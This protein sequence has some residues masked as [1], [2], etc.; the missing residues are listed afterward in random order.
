MK[1][2]ATLF[3]AVLLAVVVV[4]H[5][6]ETRQ[7]R[8]GV[9]AYR[10]DAMTQR[11]WTPTI[12]YL[13]K[14]IPGYSFTLV[15]L[16]NNDIE[17]KVANHM[18]DFVLTNPG[19]YI[20]LQSRYG[21]NRI[22]T[23]VRR[24]DAGP[25]TEFGAVIFTR[26]D[27][28]DIRTLQ[29]LRDKRFAAVHPDGFGGWWMAKQ[30]LIEHGINPERAFRSLSFRGLPQRKIVS[31][32]LRGTVDAGTVRTGVL[33]ALI[34][35]GVIKA[36][37]IRVLNPRH[38]AGFPYMLSTRLYPEWPLAVTSR[39]PLQLAREV[40]SALLFLQP[41]S[42]I[43]QAAS[44]EGWTIPLRY[45]S[46]RNMMQTLRVGPYKDLGNVTVRQAVDNAWPLL[47]LMVTGILGGFIMYMMYMNQRVRS[48]RRRL[49][50]TLHS[51]GDAVVTTNSHGV[52]EYINP[53]GEALSGL[54][55]SD[56]RGRDYR[57]IF[58]LYD[59]KTGEALDDL[60][61]PFRRREGDAHRYQDA[62]L[63]DGEGKEHA[64]KVTT[65]P[66][67]SVGG[68]ARGYVLVI[69]DVSEL[70]SLA[71]QLNYQ[72]THDPLTEMYNRREFEK[73]LDEL[74]LSISDHSGEHV[75]CY[76][77]LDH[78]K[79]VND[80]CGHMAGDVML[81]QV[82]T[83]LQGKIRNSDTLARL[84]G[85]EFGILLRDCSLDK[86]KEIGETLCNTLAAYPFKWDGKSFS[87]GG[88]MGIVPLDTL[89]DAIDLMR[90]ADTACYVAKEQGGGRVHVY[91]ADDVDLARHHGEMAWV[92]RLTEAFEHDRLQLYCH[93]M[94]KLCDG[95]PTRSRYE[96]L[97]RLVEEGE[98][99]LPGE[100]LPAAERFR[101]M[102]TIDRWVVRTAFQFI[103]K[104]G[105]RHKPHAPIFFI[106]LSGQSLADEYF[107]GFVRDQ[108][109]QQGIDPA[110]ICF[111]ITETAAIANLD[112]AAELVQGFK[113]MGCQLAL[114]DFGSGLS[115]FAYL[116]RLPVDY[117]KID[118][119]FVR[120]LLHDVVS[121]AMV[122][123]TLQI[124]R[125]M[126]IETVAEYC[127]TDE[128]LA[129][130][131]EIGVDYAQGD[132]VGKPIPLTEIPESA[133][134]AEGAG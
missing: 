22:L 39:V 48:A 94:Q 11:N 119:S 98:L 120:D 41:D 134:A 121:A 93:S 118:G 63:R 130:L 128:I 104:A 101:L 87:V 26:A 64:V 102:P 100:F 32:V 57:R 47:L 28:H 56:A 65:S 43:N 24:T 85:D 58:P 16:N 27:R 96:I 67:R 129:H 40:A 80:T 114:D 49:S 69:H 50:D 23:M 99:I 111:E 78:F 107:L 61:G 13:S 112:A 91:V 20:T 125:V 9:L 122:K 90:A 7:V 89:H 19:S 8:V 103:A 131:K 88:S 92:Q 113:N 73:Q 71:S 123:S 12:R 95:N 15:P 6:A 53:S 10:G 33:E 66:I 18:V 68:K 109:K 5:G 44:I 45:S 46:V 37:D 54:D 36:G 62:L 60:I 133:G 3:M 127:E 108:L 29:D 82:A 117:L 1:S 72:A 31:A 110:M 74:Q 75:L 25:L 97:I 42:R 55:K 30:T 77:D 52:I 106:N 86:A 76:L 83:V 115:S 79:V 59:D 132:A 124:G 126:G 51:I 105:F 17:Q 35:Q 38:V 21:V 70:R 14:A 2:I 84:G 4:A 116:R 81:K 34:N